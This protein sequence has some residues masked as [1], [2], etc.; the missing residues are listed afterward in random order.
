ML[1]TRASYRNI[2]EVLWVEQVIDVAVIEGEEIS[3]AWQSR[4]RSDGL[5]M[6][7]YI[8]YGALRHCCPP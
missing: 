2:A 4:D 7:S 6:Q 8:Q 1:K 3:I 5:V